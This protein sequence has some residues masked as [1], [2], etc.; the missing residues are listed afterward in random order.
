MKLLQ[1]KVLDI[2]FCEPIS[3]G[4]WERLMLDKLTEEDIIWENFENTTHLKDI[5]QAIFEELE[6]TYKLAV[7]HGI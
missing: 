4:L 6:S 2:M 3:E 1:D 7:Q 5:A